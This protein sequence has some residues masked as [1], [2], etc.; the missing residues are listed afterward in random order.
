M[1]TPFTIEN[2]TDIFQK[3]IVT[4]HNNY[5]EHR[6]KMKETETNKKQQNTKMR[7]E[8]MNESE[9]DMKIKLL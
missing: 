1:R 2:D 8:N 7:K 3:P 5:I 9:D 4:K 6:I